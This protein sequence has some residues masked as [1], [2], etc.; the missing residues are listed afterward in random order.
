MLAFAIRRNW[1]KPT[2]ETTAVL[3]KWSSIV[4]TIIREPRGVDDRSL[5]AAVLAY[6]L[7]LTV[8]LFADASAEAAIAMIEPEHR[9]PEN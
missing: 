2:D 7:D 4:A 3:A 9:V 1:P 8:R 5:R 6:E